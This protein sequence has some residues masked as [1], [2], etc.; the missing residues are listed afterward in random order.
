MEKSGGELDVAG[1]GKVAQSIPK[2]GWKK[3]IDTA[4]DTFSDLIAPIT[5]T[6]AGLGG[7]I[8][9]K[10]D[11]MIDVQKV[12]ASDAVHRARVKIQH[13]DKPP[14]IAPSGRVLVSAIEEASIESDDNL[15]D[16][17]ANL[18]ANELSS[19][20]VHPEFPQILSR[21]SAQDAVVLSAIADRNAKKSF[22]PYAMALRDSVVAVVGARVMVALAELLANVD[23]RSDAHVEH[24]SRIGL[25]AKREGVW[26][27][28]HFGEEFVAAVSDPSI[29]ANPIDKRS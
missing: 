26:R 1:I 23:E 20:G 14:T 24:L 4:C 5:R 15:R 29:S 28:T 16:I 8:Q 17:W 12:F 6:T 21:I 13:M 22:I 25:V 9:A 3:A 11:S 2:E 10:F 19:G 27:L 18:I 7:L